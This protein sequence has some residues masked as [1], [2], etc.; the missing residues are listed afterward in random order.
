MKLYHI[1]CEADYF[2]LS[3]INDEQKEETKRIQLNWYN[4][5]ICADNAIEMIAHFIL[6]AIVRID[7]AKIMEENPFGRFNFVE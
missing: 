2:T 4:W 7:N 1:Y 3:W 6:T 5:S